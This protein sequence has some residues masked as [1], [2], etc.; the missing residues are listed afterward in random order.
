VSR[1][2]GPYWE[3]EL[4]AATVFESFEEE[5]SLAGL[6]LEEPSLDSPV[7]FEELSEEEP[8]PLS[9]ESL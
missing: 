4:P 6:D 3:P 8:S 5:P 1:R 9:E 2:R 7:D